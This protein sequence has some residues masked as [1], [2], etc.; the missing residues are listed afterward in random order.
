MLQQAYGEDCL[1]VTFMIIWRRIFLT[2]KNISRKSCT[3][4][5]IQVVRAI[6]FSDTSNFYEK[7]W[8]YMMQP[9]RS[10]MAI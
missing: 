9:T 1:G 10:Q 4:K 5:L 6:Y 3:E 2:I 7:M 8:K